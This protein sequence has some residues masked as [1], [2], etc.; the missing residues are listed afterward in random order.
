MTEVPYKYL[1]KFFYARTNKDDTYLAQITQHNTIITKLQA[2]SCLTTRPLT[3]NHITLADDLY[4]GTTMARD[5]INLK[6]I[7]WISTLK[8]ECLRLLCLGFDPK[9]TTIT[10]DT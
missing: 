3:E 7:R 10:K 4:I 1:L 6:E 2:I 5:L 8:D 9:L